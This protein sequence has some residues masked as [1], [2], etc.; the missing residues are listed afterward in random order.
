MKRIVLG[1]MIV[2]ILFC[3]CGTGKDKLI[4]ENGK[5]DEEYMTE[6]T[7]N[8]AQLEIYSGENE[9]LNTITREEILYQYN[10]CVN[11]DGLDSEEQQKE[12]EKSV[13]GLNVEYMI[14]S[15]K[16]PVALINNQELEKIDTITIFKDS[17]IVKMEIFQENFKNIYV[18]QEFLTFYYEASEEDMEFYRS[19]T[20]E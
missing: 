9:L 18:S 11:Y 14:I 6:D 17:N 15:Y 1:L 13:E 2:S 10:R 5:E 19:L 8:L 3:G 12:L 7:G 20:E 16:Y 4:E